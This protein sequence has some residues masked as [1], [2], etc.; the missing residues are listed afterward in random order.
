MNSQM[1]AAMTS[2]PPIESAAT[3]W[4]ATLRPHTIGGMMMTNATTIIHVGHC[5]CA[6]TLFL[7]KSRSAL[8]RDID[9]LQNGKGKLIAAPYAARPVPGATVSTPI[10]WSEV[11]SK[12]DPSKFTIATVP[13]RI[14]R[15]K[16]DPLAGVL[17]EIPD[18]DAGLRSLASSLR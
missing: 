8:Y 10:R 16:D 2:S 3:M 9:F 14:A 7:S 18:I 4:R 12:L 17:V 6:T 13:R 11:T 15:M 5:F 1:I